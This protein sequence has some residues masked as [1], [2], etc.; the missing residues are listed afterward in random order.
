LTFNDYLNET[1]T[2]QLH[3][4]FPKSEAIFNID[5]KPNKI[6]L[7]VVLV[8][9]KDRHKGKGNKFMHRLIDLAKEKGKDIYLNASDMY[10]EETDMKVDDLVKWY[11]SLGFTPTNNFKLNKEMVYRV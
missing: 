9:Y 6:I 4:E 1:I 2:G 8:P 11:K 3:K 10:S 7:N 5:E